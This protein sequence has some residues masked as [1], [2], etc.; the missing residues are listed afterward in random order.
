MGSPQ[1]GCGLLYLLTSILPSDAY[2]P[3]FPTLDVTPRR[4]TN[5]HCETNDGP[6]PASIEGSVIRVPKQKS[7]PPLID[8][9]HQL[10]SENDAE[11]AERTKNL[12]EEGGISFET[13]S[14]DILLRGLVPGR[15]RKRKP[16]RG[17]RVKV[18]IVRGKC[19]GS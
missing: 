6:V 12:C 16:L 10:L 1:N 5:I 14:E 17:K 3:V 2:A 13:R 15:E 4:S 8:T 18:K 19:R 9:S 11:E 7:F